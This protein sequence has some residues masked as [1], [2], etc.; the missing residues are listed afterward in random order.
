MASML[1]LS[2]FDQMTG[3]HTYIVRTLG[4]TTPDDAAQEQALA[5]L[6]TAANK[7]ASHFPYLA[8]VVVNSG[9]S[10]TS[11]G[12]FKVVPYPPHEG[13]DKFLHIKDC[14]NELPPYAKI[15]EAKAPASMLDGRII[16]SGYGFP[17]MYPS[18]EN[19]PAY[20]VDVCLLQGGIFLTFNTQHNIMDA[21]AED[22]MVRYFARLCAGGELTQEELLMGDINRQEVFKTFP[23]T[24]N[25]DLVSWFRC[26]SALP[27][28]R[29]WPPVYADAPWH[30][31]RISASN[32]AA[33]KQLAAS[34][35]QANGQ[36]TNSTH[37]AP[38]FSTNDIVTALIWKHL[39]RSRAITSSPDQDV[40]L[41][42]AVN[43]RKSFNPPLPQTY[44]GHVV[45]CVWTRV[46][47]SELMSLPL[48]QLA[49]ALRKSLIEG[50][51]T[52]HMQSLLHVLRTESDKTTVNYGASMKEND[53]MITSHVAHSLY[54]ADFGAESGL[55]KP[56]VV[57]R[58]NLPDGRGLIYM[59]PKAR[60]GSVDIVASLTAED[61]KIMQEGEGAEEWKK[62][63]EYLG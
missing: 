15:L 22:K 20:I 48:P 51:T 28:T 9:A 21:N 55:G 35:P 45:T 4:F 31:F 6:R 58:P 41:V 46:T 11:S 47:L 29:P 25:P 38:F 61:V 44:I 56:D 1:E 36:E 23:D 26:P 3:V 12:T 43:G 57:R 13:S 50:T 16:C 40:G 10:E 52:D 8:G 27:F 62:Y 7:L 42:R 60:D 34:T 2:P 39:V 53:I 5:S 37:T 19:M 14:K 32:L 49:L 63:F 30:S 17:H 54:E 59:L 24:N 33:L 18:S